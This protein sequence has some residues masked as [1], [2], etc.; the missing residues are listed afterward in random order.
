MHSSRRSSG[1][2]SSSSSSNNNNNI[3]DNIKFRR[4]PG[5]T[6]ACKFHRLIVLLID[7]WPNSAH[8]HNREDIRAQGSH[9]QEQPQ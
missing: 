7:R 9:S 8:H 3:N 2:S 4:R 1:S 5:T 6:C